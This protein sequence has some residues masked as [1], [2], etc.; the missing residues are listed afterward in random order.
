[1][2]AQTTIIGGLVY[3]PELKFT[4]AGKAVVDFTVAHTDRYFDRDT[5]EWKDAGE[6]LFLR[7]NLWGK[8]AENL[9]ESG[10][11]KG[12]RVIVVG[13]LKQRSFEDREGNKRTVIEL[14]V[15]E[16][17]PAIKNATVKVTKTGK[18]SS[19]GSSRGSD[20]PWGSSPR[21]NTFG[22]DNEAPF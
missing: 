22:D 11:D 17:G 8:D 9:A 6:T 1:M 13:K 15:D 12:D 7:C 20:D 3:A 21:G 19:S 10:L 16:V 18:G 4:P 2:S 14:K 5:N